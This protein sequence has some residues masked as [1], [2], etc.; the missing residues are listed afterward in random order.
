MIVV[1]MFIKFLLVSC[2]FDKATVS[3]V[4]GRVRSNGT[5]TTCH[6]RQLAIKSKRRQLA[7]NLKRRQLAAKLQKRQ[8]AT[9]GKT[10]RC[11]SMKMRA[12][13]TN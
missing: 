13:F 11:V 12:L 9:K 3:W 5:T 4:I 8:L 1:A 2:L 7:T 6:K 10:R